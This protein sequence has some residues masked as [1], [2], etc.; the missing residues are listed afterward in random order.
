MAK[1]PTQISLTAVALDALSAVPL[2]R[3]LYDSIRSAILR[4]QLVSGFKLPG[5]REMAREFGVS[6]NT[7]TGAFDQLIAE[8]YLEA[9][10][11]AGTFVSKKIPDELLYAAAKTNSQLPKNKSKRELSERGKTIAATLVTFPPNQK[12]L[13]PFAPCL[14]SV[15]DFPFG[16]WAKLAGHRLR[17]PT[18]NLLN[19]GEAAGYRPLREEIA[20]Y[21]GAARGVRCAPEQVVVVSGIQ[22]AVDL[23]ARILLD[24]GDAA[25]VEDPGY[26]GSRGAM[27]AAQAR[28]VPVP[29]DAEGIEVETGKKLAPEARLACVTPSH[30]F[31]LG[32]TM[33]LARRLELLEWASRAGAWILE[34]D[35]DSEFRYEG[36]PFAALQGLD[37]DNRVIYAGTF[38]KVLSPALRI[39]YLV[40]PPDLVDA[41]TAGKALLDRHSPIFEQMILADFFA[42]GHFA[43]HVRRMR[44][45]YAERRDT[46]ISAAKSELNGL[47]EIAPSAAGLHLMGWLNNDLNDLIAARAAAKNGVDCEP[48]SALSIR[49][50][51]RQGLVLGYASFDEKEIKAGAKR[52]AAALQKALRKHQ[53][54]Q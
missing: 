2:Y 44:N 46:F 38:S 5:S 36:R 35:Y 15:E 14:P 7:I 29:V 3:Q 22:Q 9:Q 25:W 42:E 20:A 50:P 51:N 13:R 54:N 11:G 39:G 21:L 41:F 6:R 52:L 30:Q 16:L 17:Y 23:T 40:A 8:G 4:G 31:P 24:A 33:S 48:L 19:Y 49:K 12:R 10:T 18:R 26:L 43:R 1:V 27:I 34:D 37:N 47:L 28:I 53:T 45:L 32:L